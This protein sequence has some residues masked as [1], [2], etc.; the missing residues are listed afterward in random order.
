[1]TEQLEH[2][3]CCD[4]GGNKAAKPSPIRANEAQP[5]GLHQATAAFLVK[6]MTPSRDIAL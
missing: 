4:G 1:M 6:A 3:L 2:P 5:M